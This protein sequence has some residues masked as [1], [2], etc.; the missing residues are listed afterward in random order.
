[1]GDHEPS[2]GVFAVFHEQAEVRVG[3]W[4]LSVEWYKGGVFPSLRAML[5]SSLHHSP[6][7]PGAVFLT[8]PNMWASSSR[9]NR[10]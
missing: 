10:S 4:H 3:F 9:K 7:L 6:R 2:L 8:S 1:M 5:A